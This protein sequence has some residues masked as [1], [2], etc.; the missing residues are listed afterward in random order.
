MKS[1]NRRNL[2]LVLMFLVISATA[3]T[4]VAERTPVLKQ[5][6]VPH[7]YYFRE[8]YLPQVSSGPQSPAW[9]PDGQALVY[10]MQGTLW[11][12]ALGSDTATQLTAAAGYDHQPDWSP[13]G[14]TIVFS[15]YLND[16]M[17]LYL[18]DLESGV[19][20]QLTTGASVNLE[21]RWSPDGKRLAYVSTQQ[22]GR[23]HVYVGDLADGKLASSRVSADR[24]SEVE[25]YY[26]SEHDHQI[27]PVWTPDGEALLFVSNPEVPYGTGDIWYQSLSEP[28]DRFLVQSEETTWKTRP[29]VAPDGRRVIY[30]SYLGRQWHQL[31]V[32]TIAG[33]GQPF[34]LSYGDFDVTYSRWSPDGERIA[35]TSN[36]NGNTELRVLEL[37]GGRTT[38]VEI[39]S[40]EYK[41]PMGTVRIDLVD[42]SGKQLP[43]RVSVIAENGRA[44]GPDDAWLHADDSFDRSQ[45]G[46]ER[47]YFHALDTAF[48]QVPAGE[49]SI[50]VWRGPEQHV[51]RRVLAVPAGKEAAVRIGLRPLDSDGTWSDWRSGDVHVHMNYG[52]QYRNSP[53]NLSRQAAA[54]D[55]DVVFNLIVN[56]EQ[57]VPDIAYFSGKTDAVSNAAVAIQ[58]SQEFHTGYWGHLALLGLQENL[59]LPDYSAYPETAAAS[60][61]PDNAT[62]TTLAREQGAISGYVHP[63]LWPLPDP[64]S[65]ASLTNALP[66]DAALEMVDFYE[67]L[68]FADHRAS[69]EVWYRL[70]NCGFRIA[71]AGGTDAMANYASLR[72]PVGM[73]RTYVSADSWPDDPDAR[74]ATWISALRDGRSFATNG[75][76]LEFSVNGHGPGSR[77]SLDEKQTIQYSGSLRSMVPLDKLELVMNGVVLREIPLNAD[78]MSADFSASVEIAQ[79]AWLLLRASAAGPHRDVFDMYPYATTSPV[80]IDFQRSGVRSRKDADYFLAWIARVRESAE[81]HAGYNSAAER[82]RVLDHI[83]AA[84][85]VFATRRVSAP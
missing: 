63:F 28:A 19:E 10:A 42:G 31:W 21:P 78:G 13:D 36:E 51:E 25:R 43:A 33:K 82:Q 64:A 30:S 3:T 6:S 74:V 41:Q 65:D 12:Q 40:R 60:L 79:S 75:P 58:H 59:L 77:L 50:T 5:I 61:Y 9:S 39:R 16:A 85:E 68:G 18:L 80:Y 53:L 62:V 81:K 55:L 7:N 1:V 11:R 20:T 32:T 49:V 4:A 56:K 27:S 26:Y 17:E 52:G 83:D 29:D 22:D 69:A 72:G 8:M 45:S 38:G 15:R 57:R 23:F 73:N 37:P 14:R 66:I 34:P 67:V 54:E 84:R 48:V 47:R 24:Q 46:E 76:L 2:T 71:A 70:L 35:Y 44:Y